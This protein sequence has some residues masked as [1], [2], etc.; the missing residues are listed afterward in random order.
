MLS[1]QPDLDIYAREGIVWL[2]DSFEEVKIDHISIVTM[3][4]ICLPT[5]GSTGLWA[6]I[7]EEDSSGTLCNTL[8]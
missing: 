3:P 7:E 2:W 6:S 4:N 1:L 8:H 5:H